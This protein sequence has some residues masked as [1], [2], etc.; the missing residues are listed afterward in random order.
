M[1]A[2]PAMDLAVLVRSGELSA[3]ELVEASLRR[4]EEVNPQINAFTLVDAE[5]ALAAAREIRT[6]DPRP[7]AGVPVAI[8]DLGVN[9]RGLRTSN[10]SDLMG[11][12]T[13]DHDSHVVRRFRDAGFVI[14]G[15]TQTPEFGIT[16][17]TNPRRFGPAR[18]PW[19]LERTPGGSS[20]GS[21]AAVAAGCVPMAHASDGGGSIRIPAACC[22][23]VGLKPSRGRISRGPETGDSY[24]ST[25]GVVS[26]T[27]LDTAAALDVLQGYE[28][29]DS[30]WAPPPEGPY[31]QAA[32]R[33]PGVMRIGL[34][35]KPALGRDPEPE[36]I[37]AAREAAE[38]LT[39]LGHTVEEAD[40]PWDA[41]QIIEIFLDFWAVQVGVG[42]EYS[43]SVSGLAPSPE[44]VE[45]LSWT[46]YQR[47]KALDSVS[48]QFRRLALDGL[49]RMVVG[50]SLQ[51]DLLLT[52]ALGQRPLPIGA[53]DPCNEEDPIGEFLKSAD[54]TPF[55]AAF[56]VTGQPAIN[57]P[58]FEGD[59]GLPMCVQLAGRPAGEDQL[60][61]IAQQLEQ[62]RPWLHRRPP[63]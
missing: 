47:A 32:L 43:S 39:S 61:T 20:G 2:R 15:K 54:F 23:L 7:F 48:A 33:Q 19:D 60:L 10:G 24:L 62:A 8:K 34:V 37:A 38:I 52:P 29:G 56:N 6:G 42:V 14:V 53:I 27:V 35:T 46:L 28:P 49:G 13:P 4:I 45:P 55:T 58:L 26:R 51:Y 36:A 44:L 17:V 40:P 25:D 30:T 63:L 18:N 50:W 1:L 16:P 41:E 57:V 5:G 22:G 11:E 9:V 21:A 59:D 3:V 31:E 12:F